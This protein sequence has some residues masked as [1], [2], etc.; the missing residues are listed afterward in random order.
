MVFFVRSLVPGL[1]VW[2]SI[3]P[4]VGLS[5]TFN[6]NRLSSPLSFFI[7]LFLTILNCFVNN[8][9][10]NSV[11][12]ITIMFFSRQSKKL[13]K[14]KK[15]KIEQIDYDTH[16]MHYADRKNEILSPNKIL[17]NTFLFTNYKV[18]ELLWCCIP[19]GHCSNWTWVVG[20]I[21][22]FGTRLRS[23]HCRELVP[24]FETVDNL[25]STY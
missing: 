13:I 14:K 3:G 11:H 15:C 22:A 24:L 17:Q 8:V 20:D 1:F 23:T 9:F 12:K 7:I 16:R 18:L 21:L 4:K 10:T 19:C 2:L 5:Q 6:N 25:N